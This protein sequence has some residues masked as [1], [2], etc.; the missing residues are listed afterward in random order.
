MSAFCECYHHLF[1]H[2][3]PFNLW[4]IFTD[5]I[6]LVSDPGPKNDHCP[7]QNLFA[8]R[9][10]SWA[11]DSQSFLLSFDLLDMSLNIDM[12]IIRPV[13]FSG[14]SPNFN[15]T[16]WILWLSCNVVN[17]GKNSTRIQLAHHQF[18]PSFCIPV[19]FCACVLR[20]PRRLHQPS[21]R[22]APRG[23]H[24]STRSRLSSVESHFFALPATPF[25]CPR[26]RTAT[27]GQGGRSTFPALTLAWLFIEA[28]PCGGVRPAGDP[29]DSDPG[30][31]FEDDPHP[32]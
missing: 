19:N 22:G 27:L 29:V 9:E 32:R 11:F 12:K 23:E 6:S 5:R 24:L 8:N 28:S 25:Q 18:C 30:A 15:S 7:A 10:T 26:S 16:S 3:V 20:A 1:G 13:K 14:V 31:V 21:F 17:P 4:T 2:F